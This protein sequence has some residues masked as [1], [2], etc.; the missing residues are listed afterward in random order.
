MKSMVILFTLTSIL[1]SKFIDKV[2]SKCL[3]S[4]EC[5]L[6]I[7]YLSRV[8]CYH[9]KSWIV[10][11]GTSSHPILSNSLISFFWLS[12]A[13]LSGPRWVWLPWP[14]LLERW[15]CGYRCFFTGLRLS[16]A[17]YHR[18]SKN[19]AIHLTG[20]VCATV[21]IHMETLYSAKS[22]FVSKDRR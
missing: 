20:E 8:F 9:L 2:S 10:H 19:H 1:L 7:R 3:S 18:A 16:R 21:E 11:I 22:Q 4:S 14:L 17:L 13:V 6:I 12:V 5:I 15:E